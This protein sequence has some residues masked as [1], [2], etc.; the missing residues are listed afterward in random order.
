MRRLTSWLIFCRGYEGSNSRKG[1]YFINNGVYIHA[2]GMRQLF[3]LS[4]V[5]LGGIKF[6]LRYIN[7]SMKGVDY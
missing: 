3:D 6:S 2:A 5:L 1:A 4:N 7:I